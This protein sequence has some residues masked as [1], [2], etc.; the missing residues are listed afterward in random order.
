MS[1]QR[2]TGPEGPNIFIPNRDPESDIPDEALID[3][4]SKIPKGLEVAVFD[5][6]TGLNRRSTNAT[7]DR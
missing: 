2:G 4:I 7:N 3:I 5:L 1:E 6:D